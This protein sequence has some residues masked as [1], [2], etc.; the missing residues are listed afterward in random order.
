MWRDK[1][2]LP[3]GIVTGKQLLLATWRNS[4]IFINGRWLLKSL[5]QHEY[6][7]QS[8]N[9]PKVVS[10]VGGM[11]Q[12][13]LVVYIDLCIPLKFTHL[14]IRQLPTY[15]RF[16]HASATMWNSNGENQVNRFLLRDVTAKRS[17]QTGFTI[18]LIQD[19]TTSCPARDYSGFWTGAFC[20]RHAFCGARQDLLLGRGLLH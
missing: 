3:L 4:W 2:L 11:Q 6:D 5:N 13:E 8:S 1:H 15:K 18:G 10:G 12:A 7:V 20:I 17:T 9:S 16:I 19:V 14:E